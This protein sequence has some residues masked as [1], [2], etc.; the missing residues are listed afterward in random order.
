VKQ[1]GLPIDAVKRTAL[2]SI[3]GGLTAVDTGAIA[4]TH[5]LDPEWQMRRND[6]KLLFSG[7]DLP[8]MVQAVGIATKTLIAD[9]PDKLRAILLGRKRAV[10]S[11]MEDPAA[12][13]KSIVKYYDRYP[14]DVMEQVLRSL[15]G[16]PTPH[17][18]PN[19]EFEIPA[20]EGML[21]G[22]RLIGG[23]KGDVDWSKMLD[24]SFQ[25]KT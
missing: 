18:S 2:G 14:A 5:I 9:H 13:A 25:P 15:M 19:G 4:A 22:L 1:A 10:L 21:N 17:F 23:F 7:K 11:I 24:A 16:P 12:A 6:Y 3:A 8:P 20:L